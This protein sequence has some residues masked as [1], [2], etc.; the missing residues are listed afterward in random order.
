MKGLL[1]LVEAVPVATDG[2]EHVAKFESE[3]PCFDYELFDIATQEPRTFRGSGAGQA[4]DDRTNA[5]ANFDQTIGQELGDDFVRRVGVDFQ[6]PAEHTD[7]R[8]RVA[9]THFPGDHGLAGSVRDLF[10]KRNAGL[11]NDLEGDH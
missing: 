6:F 8:K 10:M 7:G 4:G 1:A 5:D 9:R 11:E 2:I 3:T